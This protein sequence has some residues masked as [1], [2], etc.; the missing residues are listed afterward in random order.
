[1]KSHRGLSS[2]VGAVFL[3][4]ALTTGMTFVT[5]SLNTIGDFSEQV[6]VQ[7]THRMAKEKEAF[8]ITSIKITSLNK[9]D[10]V[11]Q[12]I[13]QVPLKITN[14][15]IDEKGT[16]DDE[17]QKI[18]VD[19]TVGIGDTINLID[20]IDYNMDPLKGYNM[21]FVTSRGEVQSYF[22]NSS[23]EIKLH[24]QLNALPET[25]PTGFDTVILFTVYNN[26]TS[27]NVLL[28]V[29]PIID[30][31]DP[32]GV[33]VQECT[34]LPTCPSIPPSYPSLKPGE[35]TTF[36]WVYTMNGE[37]PYYEDF[38]VQL[39]NG[40]PD[41]VETIKV[42][43]TDIQFASVAATASSSQTFNPVSSS[44]GNL[45]LHQEI[46]EK[47]PTG[48]QLEQKL[49]DGGGMDIV[50]D[51]IIIPKFFTNNGTEVDID[52]GIWDVNLVYY[53][54]PFPPT[55][56]NS[57]DTN[58][59]MIFHFEDNGEGDDGYE[60]NSFNCMDSTGKGKFADYRG[61]SVEWNQFGGPNNTGSYTFDGT[62]DYFRIEVA[63]C[64]NLLNTATTIAGWF[65]ASS[66]GSGNDYIY[67][68]GKDKDDDDRFAVMI[69]GGDD[70]KFSVHTDANDT[71]ICNSINDPAYPTTPID[72]RDDQWHHFVGVRESDDRCR[73]Y[74]DG[75]QV[76]TD[77]AGGGGS[78]IESQSPYVYVG[79]RLDEK[80]HP[81]PVT[82]Y[83]QGSLDD[84]MYWDNYAL[85]ADQAEDLYYT[86][87][88]D[89]AHE[90]TFTFRT[91]DGLG[92]DLGLIFTE[93]GYK[94]NFLDGK[95]DNKAVKS[96]KYSS[97]TQLARTIGDQERIQLLMDLDILLDPYPTM[98][99][100][101]R[102]D[103]NSLTESSYIDLPLSV[104][105]S[106]HPTTTHDND[107]TFSTGITSS[108]P[109]GTWLTKAGTRIILTNT[110]TEIS[111]AG[112]IDTVNTVTLSESEDSIFIQEEDHVDL[113]FHRITLSPNYCLPNPPTELCSNDIPP[114][115]G[116][117]DG[118]ILMIGYNDQ[119]N[120]N[121]WKVDLGKIK[122]I[123]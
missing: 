17:V 88:G 90:I 16:N 104:G 96:F 73:L 36:K 53:S 71:A 24:T 42:K 103:D 100:T 61:S 110:D 72:Y 82:D 120:Q 12:N 109:H 28:N 37:S 44:T 106:F 101:L 58:G 49:A 74:I 116:E 8:E 52:E 69:D 26:A 2:A 80:N 85:N 27:N 5:T 55:L 45:V 77:P 43:M 95:R 67:F 35:S 10:G 86:S 66:S 63:D 99:M 113:V 64:N 87:Y 31:R 9:L 81:Y 93:S 84:I 29:T 48:Y 57:M 21:K 14:L 119:G 92:N 13:G 115:P 1:M 39:Q 59:G 98:K 19:V 122:V 107:S 41:N 47:I 51:G 94:M 3:I 6:I 25:I 79:A 56:E 70:V 30:V 102:I 65:K 83:F 38:T 60:D 68:A 4:I 40:H 7:D 22:V 32:N 15:W 50:L 117:Y 46:V 75:V 62:E 23:D 121:T 114:P 20:F 78:F 76:D 34:P 123:E 33:V 89:D 97:G 91:T 108:G 118:Q 111:Y 112:I 11:I 54:E 18:S 105:A